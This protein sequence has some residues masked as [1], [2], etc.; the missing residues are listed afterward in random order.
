MLVL[1][2]VSFWN[3]NMGNN[4]FKH[5]YSNVFKIKYYNFCQNGI[6]GNYLEFWGHYTVFFL[7]FSCLQNV[8]DCYLLP[9]LFSIFADKNLW[10]LSQRRREGVVGDANGIISK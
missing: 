8:M 7:Y 1:S 3:Q 10:F 4:A 6:T 2:I 5:Q 9:S